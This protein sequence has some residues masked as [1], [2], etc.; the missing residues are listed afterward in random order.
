[1]LWDIVLTGGVSDEVGLKGKKEQINS[2]VH[3]CPIPTLW[4]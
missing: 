4:I 1:M 3:V 2:W